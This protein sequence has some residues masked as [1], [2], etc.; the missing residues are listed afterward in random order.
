[1][2][3]HRI[4]VLILLLVLAWTTASAATAQ[5]PELVFAQS[6]T[7]PI[8]LTAPHGGNSPVPGAPPRTRGERDQDVRTGELA[9]ALA[10]RLEAI[11]CERPYVVIA[12]FH[13]RYI[14]ANRAEAESYEHP[15][16]RPA[17]LAYHDSIRRFVDEIRARYPQGGILIDVHGQAEDP[18]RIHRGT[19]NGTTVSRLLARH[20]EESLVGRNSI[21]GQLQAAGYDVFPPGGPLQGAREDARY[22]GGYTVAT[23]GSQHPDGIDAIQLEIGRAFRGPDTLPALTDALANAIAVF[24]TT[25]VRDQPRCS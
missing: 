19:R 3:P 17:Y 16:A 10:S 23:Y 9:E 14:D 5:P 25:Y 4:A 12:L 13:R 6:G 7:L 21:A 15:D 20:G 1:M 8:I 24:S 11:F 18:G 22:N 2:S